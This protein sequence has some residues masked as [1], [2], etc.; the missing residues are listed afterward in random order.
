MKPFIN[1]NFLLSNK[2]AERLYHEF[3]EN[4]PIIDFHC[5]L[6]PAMIAEDSQFEN[7]A[8]AWL[9]GDHYKW[10]AMR[11]NGISEM[12]CTGDVSDSEKFRKW[13]ETVP[14]TIPCAGQC[15]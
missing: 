13:A 12:Y 10:R 2:T 11:A 7:L 9:G 4:Q 14:S 5:H 15:K 8:Q 1:E 3:S 6:S